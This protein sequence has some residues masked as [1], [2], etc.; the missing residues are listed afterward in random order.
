[1]KLWRM[2]GW[3]DG[4]MK[5]FDQIETRPTLSLWHKG[6]RY[7]VAIR[8]SQAKLLQRSKEGKK[9]QPNI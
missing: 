4:W 3:M 2:D 9:Q 1:M 8:L 5:A 7:E 6:L